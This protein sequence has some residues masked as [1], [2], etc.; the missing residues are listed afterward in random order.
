MSYSW[1]Y[2]YNHYEI[3]DDYG[4]FIESAQDRAELDEVLE[5]LTA[6]DADNASEEMTEYL[7][8]TAEEMTED[9]CESSEEMT[10][11]FYN[12]SCL[13]AKGKYI[14]NNGKRLFVPCE[15]FR[16]YFFV[17]RGTSADAAYFSIKRPGFIYKDVNVECQH[18]SA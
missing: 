1:R 7:I 14:T 2:C 12:V 8:W 6:E 9:C 13:M 5:K 17:A 10:E 3:V 4:R 15:E 18:A 16:R 11:S